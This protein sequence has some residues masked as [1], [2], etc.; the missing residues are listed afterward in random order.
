MAEPTQMRAD[1]RVKRAQ[2]TVA[3]G[4]AEASS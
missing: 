1:A 2:P 4:S 3:D